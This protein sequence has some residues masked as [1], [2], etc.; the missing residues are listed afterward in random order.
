SREIVADAHAELRAEAMGEVAR[1]DVGDRGDAVDG[2]VLVVVPAQVVDRTAHRLAEARPRV[3]E[4]VTRR[5]H[6][7][8][9]VHQIFEPNRR[10]PKAADIPGLLERSSNPVDVDEHTEQL[11]ISPE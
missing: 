9:A 10:P 11:A 3:A 4:A 6:R 1:G 2:Q 5:Q 7:T 8:D